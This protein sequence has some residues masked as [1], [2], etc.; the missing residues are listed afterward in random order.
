MRTLLFWVLKVLEFAC[1]VGILIALV[2][3]VAFL[4]E[5]FNKV[6]LL[7]LSI[8]W[9]FIHFCCIAKDANNRFLDRIFKR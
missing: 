7:S 8:L 4:Y 9:L 1:L 2:W 3:G 5:H 6:I